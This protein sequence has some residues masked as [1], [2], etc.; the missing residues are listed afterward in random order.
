MVSIARILCPTDFSDCSRRAFACATAVARAYD[1]RVTMLHVCASVP[2]PGL[3]PAVGAEGLQRGL[4]TDEDRRDLVEEM[5]RS[6]VPCTP[7][8]PID[9]VVEEASD[10]RHE[11]LARADAIGADLLVMG[12]HGRSGF[13]RFVLGSVTERIVRQ[14][15]CPVLVVPPQAGEAAPAV[16]FRRILCAVDFSESSTRGLAYALDLAGDSGADVLL[17]HAIDRSPELELQEDRTWASA[18][19]ADVRGA[20][21]AACLRRLQGL[22]PSEAPARCTVHPRVIEG[23]A[24]REI[25]RVAA[26]ET[27]DLI[28]MGVQGRGAVDLLMFGSNTEQVLRGARCPVLTVRSQTSA[29]GRL[30]SG[31]AHT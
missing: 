25:L 29:H 21:E 22:I 19:V 30:G 8:V 26:D 4:L 1:A 18:Q 9:F 15:A 2:V 17:L 28:V 14:A 10:V 27:V 5:R 13:D 3:M 24:H 6:A 11:I 23:P 20:A 16:P 7:D 12:S 31:G